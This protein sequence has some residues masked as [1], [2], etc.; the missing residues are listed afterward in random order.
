MCLGNLRVFKYSALCNIV[1]SLNYLKSLNSLIPQ[2][3]S[4]KSSPA[5][6]VYSNFFYIFAFINYVYIMEKIKIFFGW[7]RKWISPVYVAML[8]AAFVLW[9]IT[10]LG[11]EYTTDHEVTVVIDN[12]EY[13][14]NCT[15]RGKGTD[16]IYYTMSSTRS[17]FTIPISDLTLDKP[18]VDNDGNNIIHVTAESLKLALAQRM[19]NIEVVSVGSVPVI[20][21]GPDAPDSNK[22]GTREVE[23]IDASRRK[24]KPTVK[25]IEAKGSMCGEYLAPEA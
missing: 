5:P 15:I 1:R 22:G 3:V 14:V 11:D 20:K 2:H 25:T 4:P 17:R 13:N 10:K 6:Y 8:V 18:M 16:L 24:I 12:V 19:D 9:F 7:L 21:S 23:A